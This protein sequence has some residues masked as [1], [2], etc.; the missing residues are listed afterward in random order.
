[1]SDET[2]EVDFTA[3]AKAS[4]ETEA[5]LDH[6]FA[7]ETD[8]DEEIDVTGEAQVTAETVLK[9]DCAGRQTRMWSLV[10]RRRLFDGCSKGINRSSSLRT[11]CRGK[12]HR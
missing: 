7:E 4:P 11:F 8:T 1:M 3:V 6:N 12:R 9:E 2:K 5:G 10:K